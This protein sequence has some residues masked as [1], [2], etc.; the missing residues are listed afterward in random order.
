MSVKIN[1]ILPKHQPSTNY[2]PTIKP[3]IA[4]KTK[5]TNQAI[6]NLAVRFN[7]DDEPKPAKK[8]VGNLYLESLRKNPIG[9]EFS[10]KYDVTLGLE[11][12]KSTNKTTVAD[13]TKAFDRAL[14][15][16][17]DYA[18]LTDEEVKTAA[19]T[20]KD[21]NWKTAN[22][23]LEN[24][25]A[26]DNKPGQMYAKTSQYSIELA[27]RAGEAV[28]NF[29]KNE[30]ETFDKNQAGV[31]N[32]TNQKFVDQ[33]RVIYNSIVNNVESAINLG[34]DG[35]LSNGGQ[36]PLVLANPFRPRV[37][38]SGIKADYQSEMR[39]RDINGKLDGNGL[40]RGKFTE[41]VV[42]I[43]APLVVGKVTTPISP[44]QSVVPKGK[45]IIE[46]GR[47]VTFEE[48][49]VA[50]KLVREGKV[51][52]VPIEAS[53]KGIQNVRTPDF[54]VDGVKTELKTISNLK[55]K[56]MSA[57]LSRRILDGAGQGSNIIIDA[58]NQIGMTEEIAKSGIKRAY[59]RLDQLGSKRLSEV[60][61]IGN[62][63][64]ITIKF[65]K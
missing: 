36:K 54:I 11:V 30:S 23:S 26:I 33:G 21:K 24:L 37:D 50:N 35:I 45:L 18:M 52:E 62:G 12:R 10:R 64:D 32:E 51:V 40:K 34:V 8:T 65:N 3:K 59:G 20:I 9:D 25:R 29:R 7:G 1:P 14:F 49:I 27:K 56:D 47:T 43:L 22:W 16:K 44:I 39:R 58:R 2:K 38:L 61:V 57:S 19:D 53:N 4:D 63:F 55:G 46:A 42:T 31:E 13:Y 17:A 48:S 28:L 6:K 5:Q 41:G 60:R 15:N